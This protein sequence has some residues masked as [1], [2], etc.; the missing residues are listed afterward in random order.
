M[1]QSFTDDTLHV[2]ITGVEFDDETLKKLKGGKLKLSKILNLKK[3]KQVCQIAP[4]KRSHFVIHCTAGNMPDSE[5]KDLINHKIRSKAHVYVKKDGS[6]IRIW[7]FTE[8]YVWA[9]KLETYTKSFRGQMFHV[10]VN[11]R[12]PDVPTEE[13]YLTL[14]D[15]YIEASNIED[16]WPIIVPHIE[17]DRG[18]PNGHNDPTDFDYNYFYTVLKEKGVPIDIVPKFDH[19]RYWGDKKYKIPYDTDKNS[20]PPVLSGNPHQ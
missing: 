16:C 20:W 6:I 14:A 11:Y 1:I 10:E 19:N 3:K 2:K 12:E 7:P 8:K 13:Q 9:T 15:L 4:N 18:I 5:I 17:I